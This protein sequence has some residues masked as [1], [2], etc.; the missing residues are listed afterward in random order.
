MKKLKPNTKH[1]SE[2]KAVGLAL[3]GAG[4]NKYLRLYKIASCG[5]TQNIAP[6]NVRDRSFRCKVC[7]KEKLNKEAKFA[8]VTLIGDGRNSNYRAYRLACGHVID[9]QPSHVRIKQLSKCPFCK[10]ENRERDA[11]SAGI[12]I[13]SKGRNCDHRIYRLACGHTKEISLHSVRTKSFKC[14]ECQLDKITQEANRVGLEIVGAGRN[15]AYRAY[16]LSCGHIQEIHMG[17]VRSGLFSCHQCEGTHRTQP[18]EVYLLRVTSCGF[19]WL[20]LGYTK[21]VNS[22]IG[23]YRLPEDSQV[24]ILA[25]CDFD[26]GENAHAFEIGIHKL[27]RKHKLCP[28]LMKKYHQNGYS[29]CYPIYMEATLSATILAGASHEAG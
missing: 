5:H 19:T 3:L 23:Q 15:C 6:Q 26:T 21:L 25:V 12:E 18:S 8:G 17:G 16:K 7:I 14:E 22:R 11:E 1:I 29:E 27:H 13:I 4:I 28:S 9:L 20:K 2:A 24:E 10:Q